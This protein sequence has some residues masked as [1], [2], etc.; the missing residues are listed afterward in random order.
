[1]IGLGQAVG[2]CVRSCHVLQTRCDIRFVRSQKSFPS[3]TKL[4]GSE[5]RVSLQ[6]LFFPFLIFTSNLNSLDLNSSFASLFAAVYIPTTT[7]TTKMDVTK[8]NDVS[9]YCLS[10]GPTIPEWLGDRARRN[11]SKK[12]DAVRRRIEL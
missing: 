1:M 6:R 12:D 9:I 8:R 7:P 4:S 3:A 5:R 10:S 2:R 11:L